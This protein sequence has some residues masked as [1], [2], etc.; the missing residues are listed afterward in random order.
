MTYHRGDYVQLTI[1]PWSMEAFVALA[2]ENG[3]SLFV[4]FDGAA[5]LA[6]GSGLVIGMMPLFQEHDGTWIEILRRTPVG[7]EPRKVH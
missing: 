4:M 6:D 2:S 3:R 1:G 7:V 5:P